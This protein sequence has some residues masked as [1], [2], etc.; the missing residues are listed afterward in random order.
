M[1]IVISKYRS[2]MSNLMKLKRGMP[3]AK[4]AAAADFFGGEAEKSRAAEDEAEMKRRAVEKEKIQK[5]LNLLEREYKER[6]ISEK[7]YNELRAR[8]MKKLSDLGE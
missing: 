1:G 2:K 3:E 7:A 8:N 5:V 4:E 6:I